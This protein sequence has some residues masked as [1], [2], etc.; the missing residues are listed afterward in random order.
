MKYK[1]IPYESKKLS[2]FFIC[3]IFLSYLLILF[4]IFFVKFLII[5]V[6]CIESTSKNSL[7]EFNDID[8]KLKDQFNFYY[9]T[10]KYYK[11]RKIRQSL[12][13]CKC[14]IINYCPRGPPGEK[15]FDGI[16]GFYGEK[17]STGKPGQ[18]FVEIITTKK[19]LIEQ[20]RKCF[21]GLKGL[22]GKIGLPG[23]PGV[24]GTPGL[25]GI[26]GKSGTM[27]NIGIIGEQGVPG[28][29][30]L[31]GVKGF[32]GRDGV[33]SL[34]GLRGPFG[35]KGQIGKKGESG[36]PGFNGRPGNIGKQGPPGQPGI[37][38]MPGIMGQNGLQG[39]PGE[40]GADG[41][42]C[43]CQIS[44]I[45]EKNEKEEYI[46]RQP[47]VKD[48]IYTDYTPLN[49]EIATKIK[50]IK[51]DKTTEMALNFLETDENKMYDLS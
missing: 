31:N 7:K 21:P 23:V 33:R 51:I 44:K 1:Y 19:N 39:I 4:H 3:V 22:P 27:G 32:N 34:Q 14:K 9:S 50:N 45:K 26:E 41:G 24:P 40:I 29:P 2:C 30:G 43:K 49:V 37:D 8:K 12:I 46:Q 35:S 11:T 38:G 47:Y 18:P 10:K 25:P 13:K 20:C 48:E 42:Y 28:T 17:G 6:K 5:K 16:P 15:G 36:Y